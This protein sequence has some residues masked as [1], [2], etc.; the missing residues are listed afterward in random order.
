ML[1]REEK[2]EQVELLKERIQRASALLA[3]E[4]RGL[5]VAESTAL[6]GQMRA[7]GA[8]ELEMRVAKNTLVRR[9]VTGTR[10]EA[11]ARL[12]TGPIALGIAYEEP[13]GLAKILV[14]YGKTNE[15]LKLRGGVV[16]GELLDAAGIEALA[17]LPSKQELRGMLAGTLQ[18]PLRNLAGT[19]HALLGHVRNALD[20]RL[21]Q[22]EQS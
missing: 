7:A 11:L 6:R 20:Q 21:E 2:A 18:A 13:A 16:D 8:G 12:C 4:Y 15:K 19:L 17:T 9:A 1:T 3:F 22:L 10:S 5:T 14:E